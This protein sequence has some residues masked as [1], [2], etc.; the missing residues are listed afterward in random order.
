MRPLVIEHTFDYT[1]SPT[2]VREE[3]AM[4]ATAIESLL[5]RRFHGA[6]VHAKA[7]PSRSGWTTG[8]ADLDRALGPVG[9]PHGRIT[10][11]FGESSSGKTSLV[12]ALLAAVTVRG[13]IGAYVDPD[14]ALFA[15]SAQAA[16]IDLSRLIVV[17]P[18]EAAT[19]R[20]AVDAIVRS[21]ACAVTVLDGSS[22][23]ALQSHH[24]AR[25]AAHAEKNG[26]SLVVLS[27]GGSGPLASFASLRV[28]LR[29]LSPLWQAGSDGSARLCGYRIACTV[30]KSKFSSPGKSAS[31]DVRFPDV[32]G[33][34]YVPRSC[35][36]ESDATE[37]GDVPACHASGDVRACHESSA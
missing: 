27:R 37:A 31:F 1:N 15:P 12:Y 10:E 2:R 14:R 4:S 28:H 19:L 23:D 20:R 32:A 13:D 18:S 22:A 16:G 8:I 24:Y 21:G 9:V 11:L 29:G 17:R 7:A 34:W 30:A 6:A 36:G 25:L 33:S 26:T 35:A 3:S 5:E